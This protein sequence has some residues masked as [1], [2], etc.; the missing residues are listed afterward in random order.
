M[1]FY[2]NVNVHI[3]IHIYVNVNI[4]ISVNVIHFYFTAKKLTKEMQTIQRRLRSREVTPQKGDTQLQLRNK[5]TQRE[6]LDEELSQKEERFGNLLYTEDETRDLVHREMDG[7][8]H[9]HVFNNN[10]DISYGYISC[11]RFLLTK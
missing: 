9:T 11:V 3:K 1:N 7:Y 5:R 10:Y 6:R 4:Y 2:V 8:I